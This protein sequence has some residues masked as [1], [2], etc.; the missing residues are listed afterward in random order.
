MVETVDGDAIGRASIVNYNGKTVYDK[1]AKPEKRITDFRSHVS[2]ITPEALK[3]AIPF[4]QCR[5]EVLKIIEGKILV[6]HTLKGDIKLLNYEHPKHLIRDVSKYKKYQDKKGSKKS[7]KFLSDTFLQRVI[8]EGAHSSVEDSQAAMG[9]YREVEKDWENML[10]QKKRAHKRTI[11]EMF[12]SFNEKK[13]DVGKDSNAKPVKLAKTEETG[14][15][16]QPEKTLK[17]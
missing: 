1:F 17:N 15:T 13:S 3:H 9:L 10:K 16:A 4:S 11:G 5:E 14:D 12:S 7:L 2:G 8:Q 6:G